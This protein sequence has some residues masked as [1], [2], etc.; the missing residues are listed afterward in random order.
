MRYAI[1][2][3][4]LALAACEGEQ[5]HYLATYPDASGLYDASGASVACLDASATEGDPAGTDV[6]CEWMCVTLDGQPVRWVRVDFSRASTSEAWAVKW[7]TYDL[8][9]CDAP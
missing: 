1:L 7:T 3:A 2:A 6:S 4:V 9:A 5:K 8:A